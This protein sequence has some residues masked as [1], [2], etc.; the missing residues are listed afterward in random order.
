MDSVW[1]LTG[2]AN[3]GS[4]AIVVLIVLSVLRGWLV[5]RR[6]LTDCQRECRDWKQAALAKDDTINTM[7]HQLDEAQESARVATAT[8]QALSRAADR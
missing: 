6:I 5:P 7:A 4:G 3:I 1:D 8:L 2:L